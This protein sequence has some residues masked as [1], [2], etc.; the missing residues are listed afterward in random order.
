[1]SLW[2]SRFIDIKNHIPSSAFD[3]STPNIKINS[4]LVL[5]ILKFSPKNA[6]ALL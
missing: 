3:T 6:S 2:F 4:K 5:A 1:M